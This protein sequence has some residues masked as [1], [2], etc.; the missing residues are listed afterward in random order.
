MKKLIIACFAAIVLFTT[1]TANAEARPNF[2]CNF[3]HTPS[4]QTICQSV[5]LSQLDRRMRLSY[6]RL[7]RQMRGFRYWQDRRELRRNQLAWFSRRNRC[8][9]NRRCLIVKYKT[10]IERLEGW[11]YGPV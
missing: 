11:E 10:R 3:S 9:S 8:G 5:R 7:L 6:K 4:V 1:G 2:R